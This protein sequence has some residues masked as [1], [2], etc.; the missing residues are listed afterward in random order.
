MSPA[1]S[2]ALRPSHRTMDSPNHGL[3]EPWTHHTVD[4]PIHTRFVFVG[5]QC[6]TVRTLVN[7]P[8][9]VRHHPAPMIMTM[10]QPFHGKLDARG[11]VL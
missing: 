11:P 3:P 9:G 6:G 2:P 7:G 10:V 1:Q 8:G 4:L 5:F